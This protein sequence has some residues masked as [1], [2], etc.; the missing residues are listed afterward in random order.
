MIRPPT[1]K[2]ESR[3]RLN[4]A[5][6]FIQMVSGL[7]DREYHQDYGNVDRYVGADTA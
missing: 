7:L 1:P 2:T 4:L 5:S 6:S 3:M